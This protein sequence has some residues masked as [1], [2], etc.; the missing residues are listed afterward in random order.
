MMAVVERADSEVVVDVGVPLEEE[1][2]EED[3]S[4]ESRK[5]GWSIIEL[6]A[7][8]MECPDWRKAGGG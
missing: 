7:S 2:E 4:L 6:T 8:Q 1:E 5:R 3:V